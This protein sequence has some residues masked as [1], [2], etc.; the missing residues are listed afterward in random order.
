MNQNNST[1]SNTMISRRAFSASTVA[2]GA[3]AIFASPSFALTKGLRSENTLKVGIVGCGGRGTGAVIQALKADP[4]TVLWAMGDVF[5][6]KINPCL[7]YVSESMLDLDDENNTDQWSKKIQVEG[8][9][10]SGFDSIHKVLASGVDVMILTTPPAF[11][12]EHLRLTIEAGKHAF[13]EKPVAV[14]APGVRS[15]L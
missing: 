11:R 12:P 9:K 13:V 2:L 6:D 8:R 4:G 5:E 1:K 10:F 3:S 7:H 15:V 14:D